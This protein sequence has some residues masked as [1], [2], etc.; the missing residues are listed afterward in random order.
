MLL[1]PTV[2]P[3]SKAQQKLASERGNARILIADDNTTN[4]IVTRAQLK[5]LGYKADAVSNGAEAV[6]ALPLCANMS[7]TSR[8]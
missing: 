3:V 8:P 5:R 1:P 7:E 6:E 2:E 4:W